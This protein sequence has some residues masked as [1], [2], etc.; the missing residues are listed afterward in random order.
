[1]RARKQKSGRTFYY[2][3][4]GGRP[5]K[6]IPLG[7]DMVAAIRKWAELEGERP[8][9]ISLDPVFSEA[10]EAYIRDV[11][12]TKSPRTQI[13]NLSE[14]EYLREYFG[15]PP[16]PL[17]QITPQHIALYKRWRS[18]KAR[19]WYVTKGR[20]VPANPGAVRANRDLALFSHIFNH[21]RTIGLTAAP[22]PCLGVPKNTETG[23]DVYVYDNFYA[24]VYAQARQPLKDAMDVLYLTG[25]RP[26]D[27]VKMTDHD[28]RGGEIWVQ[29]GKTKKKIRLLIEGELAGVIARIKERRALF[30]VV[31]PTLIL[32]EKGEALTLRN[33]Q[34]MFGEAREQAGLPESDRFQLRDLRAKAATDTA[35]TSGDIRQAQRQMGHSS[36]AMTEHY[37][38]NRK[39]D[40]VK[41]TR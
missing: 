18:E 25:Q 16:A 37:V 13:D 40:R 8:T 17:D 12:P 10:A 27:V 41:P 15:N 29:Q 26:Q 23:R 20:A 9:G 34:K 4:A 31:P 3:D 1:M 32:T 7:S 35:E 14:L 30:K 24:A 6:E 11:L 5:R 28:I 21:A 22:N 38:R 39:G 36:V 19:E 33:L 2:Y